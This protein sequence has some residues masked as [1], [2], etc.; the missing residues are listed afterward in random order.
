[1]GFIKKE[2]PQEYRQYIIDACAGFVGDL[3]SQYPHLSTD[4]IGRLLVESVEL[5][6]LRP[7]LYVA[8]Q[9]L[10]RSIHPVRPI[11]LDTIWATQRNIAVGS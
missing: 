10:R 1:M 7:E 9:A 4:E 8:W 2:F 3:A 5:V 11:L 6:F